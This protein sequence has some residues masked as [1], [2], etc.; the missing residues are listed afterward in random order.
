MVYLGAGETGGTGMADFS[1]IEGLPKFQHRCHSGLTRRF[2]PRPSRSGVRRYARLCNYSSRSV[3][4][5]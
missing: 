4:Y 3:A 5:R 2:L 1:K